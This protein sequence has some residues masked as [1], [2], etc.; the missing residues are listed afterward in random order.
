MKRVGVREF[1][2]HATQYLAGDEVLAVE[3]HGQPIGFYIPARARRPEASRAAFE[4]LER[5]IERV[6]AQTGL[7]EEEFVRFFDLSQPGPAVGTDPGD[8]RGVVPRAAGR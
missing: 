2:D 4:R 5:A 8:E 3:R 1:R 6:L 7:S